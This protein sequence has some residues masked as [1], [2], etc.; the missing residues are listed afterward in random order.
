[1]LKVCAKKCNQCLFTSN[2]I[3]SKQRM[4]SI[5]RNCLKRDTHFEC[6]KGTIN[7]EQIVCA[8]WY[9]QYTSQMLSIAQRLN[10]IEFVE[11]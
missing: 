6:H 7:N 8:G 1:M 11:M 4:T 3:V 10:M 5:V 9:N 2:R